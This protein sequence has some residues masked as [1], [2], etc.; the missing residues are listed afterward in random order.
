[1]YDEAASCYLKALSLNP[2]AAHIWSSLRVVFNCMSRPG[3]AETKREIN[4]EPPLP[5]TVC[6]QNAFEFA[7][8][9]SATRSA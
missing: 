8:P 6:T 5:R 2:E 4:P 3:S 1:M 7:A 9:L